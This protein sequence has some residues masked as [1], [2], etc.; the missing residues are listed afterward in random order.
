MP[1][2]G[3][4]SGCEGVGWEIDSTV[5]QKNFTLNILV[6]FLRCHNDFFFFLLIYVRCWFVLFKSAVWLGLGSQIDMVMLG[7]DHGSA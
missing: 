7:N 2:T 4:L 5:R 3:G 1:T 6:S